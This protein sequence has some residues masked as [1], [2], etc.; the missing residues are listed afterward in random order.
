MS[1]IMSKNTI[2]RLVIILENGPLNP[3]QIMDEYK[4]RWPKSQPSMSRLSNLLSR[5]KQFRGIE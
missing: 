4:Q 5:Y 1:D 2:K 3:H